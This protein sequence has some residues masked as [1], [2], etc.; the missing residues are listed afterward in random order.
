MSKVSELYQQVI[1]DHNQR[2]RNFHKLEMANHTAA[3]YNPLCG[4][5]LN[6]YLQLED[7]HISDIS[8]EGSAARSRKLPRA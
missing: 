4:D 1:L 5:H 8:F 3:G 7:D 6:V 2:P